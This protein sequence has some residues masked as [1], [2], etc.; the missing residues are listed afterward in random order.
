[1]Y[2]K[3]VP[4]MCMCKGY[5]NIFNILYSADC[6]GNSQQKKESREEINSVKR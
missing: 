6:K 4:Y 3:G 1:M 2:Y 5:T